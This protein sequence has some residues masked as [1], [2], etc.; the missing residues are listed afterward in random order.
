MD[1]SLLREFLC[2]P[3]IEIEVH[4][5]DRK[6]EQ[7]V[8]RPTLFGD[9]LEDEKISSVGTVES[10]LHFIIHSMGET[11]HGIHMVWPN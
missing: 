3:G 10:R 2:G 4:D 8:L 7:V 1:I 5:R 9:D 6:P 11:D